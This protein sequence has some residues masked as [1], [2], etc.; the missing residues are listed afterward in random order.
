MNI[1]QEVAVSKSTSKRRL[2]KIKYLKRY[3]TA[4]SD[5]ILLWRDE[6]KME[7]I[8]L[9][10]SISHHHCNVQLTAELLFIFTDDVTADK[11]SLYMQQEKFIP[12]HIQ[13][14][15]LLLTG[16]IFTLQIDNV[17]KRTSRTTK[18]FF[19]EKKE[20]M[21][22]AEFYLLKVK[23]QTECARSYS[24]KDQLEHQQEDHITSA[25]VFELQTSGSS[26]VSC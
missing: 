24:T 6:P 13:T 22:W 19:K 20:W 1:L 8:S 17:Q 7:S 2:H 12:V 15:A 18:T 23:L 5:N 26:G 14:N 16:C 4:M 11:K 10:W 25:D 9:V 3:T 21:L